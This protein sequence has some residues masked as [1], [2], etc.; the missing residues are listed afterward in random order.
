MAFF[1]FLSLT[2]RKSFALASVKKSFTIGSLTNEDGDG[3]ENCKK[4]VGLDWQNNKF[5][6]VQHASW[7]MS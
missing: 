1:R 3:N 6:R 7:Y 4:A 5:A 2:V